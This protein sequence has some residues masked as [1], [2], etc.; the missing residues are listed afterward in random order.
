MLL[1]AAADPKK[2]APAGKATNAPAQVVEA[3]APSAVFVPGGRNPFYP[4]STQHIKKAP[5][6]IGDPPPK[7]VPAVVLKRNPYEFL[8]ITGLFYSRRPVVT[9]NKVLDLKVGD[10]DVELEVQTKDERGAPQTLNLKITCLA[11]KKSS[12]LIQ[13]EGEPAPKE[14]PYDE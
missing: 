9:L 6:K 7:D 11:I 2:A 14:L 8:K 1:G 13:V 3:P 10:K 4:D 12:A 5:I